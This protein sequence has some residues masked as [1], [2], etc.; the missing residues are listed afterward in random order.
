MEG[1]KGCKWQT[2]GR[3]LRG[4]RRESSD[5]ESRERRVSLRGTWEDVV[6][7]VCGME[8]G[9]KWRGSIPTPLGRHSAFSKG[10]EEVVSWGNCL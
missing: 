5:R 6:I 9:R 8:R 2:P 4:V 10:G 7:G 1:G 3:L